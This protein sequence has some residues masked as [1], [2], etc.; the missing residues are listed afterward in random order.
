MEIYCN[1]L[2]V[3]ITTIVVKDVRSIEIKSLTVWSVSLQCLAHSAKLDSALSTQKKRGAAPKVEYFG[4]Y[5]TIFENSL[6]HPEGVHSRR[7]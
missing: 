7:D 5:E 2:I 4:K 3:F 6:L 1:S